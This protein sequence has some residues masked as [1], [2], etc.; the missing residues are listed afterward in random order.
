MLTVRVQPILAVLT[1]LTGASICA[2]NTTLIALTILFQ[3]AGLLAMATLCMKA[4]VLDLWFESMWVSVFN[5][6]H[7]DLS[8][9]VSIMV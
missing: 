6:I 1:S 2:S 3:A 5:C 9:F 7:S 8:L 4:L